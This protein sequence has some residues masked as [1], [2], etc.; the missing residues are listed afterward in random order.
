MNTEPQ[1]RLDR[2]FTEGTIGRLAIFLLVSFVLFFTFKAP[3]IAILT[4]LKF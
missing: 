4:S 3:I 1:S 2:W